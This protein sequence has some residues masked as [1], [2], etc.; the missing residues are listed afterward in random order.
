MQSWERN[1]RAKLGRSRTKARGQRQSSHTNGRKWRTQA[2]E[3]WAELRE[4][5]RRLDAQEL[6][7]LEQGYKAPA[8]RP[9]GELID[10]GR[11]RFELEL[12]LRKRRLR[13]WLKGTLCAIAAVIAL[14]L[15]IE[16]SHSAYQ[17]CNDPCQIRQQESYESVGAG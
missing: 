13:G 6:E 10:E 3:R 11:E 7:Q 2:A 15:L 1:H 5:E 14:W 16:A 9:L 12:R 4:E 8:Q 17:G